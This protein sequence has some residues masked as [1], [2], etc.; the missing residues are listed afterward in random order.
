MNLGIPLRETTR[1]WLKG[2]DPAVE[3]QQDYSHIPHGYGFEL[4]TTSKVLGGHESPNLMSKRGLAKC[5]AAKSK[6]GRWT[7]ELSHVHGKELQ[8]EPSKGPLY[9]V[10]SW[11]PVSLDNHDTG[12]WHEIHF[13]PPK[14][15]GMI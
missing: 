12:G 1:G 4:G 15:P 5:S 10:G 7:Q 13:A 6:K 3:L 8:A 14:K 2:F 11:T 9:L